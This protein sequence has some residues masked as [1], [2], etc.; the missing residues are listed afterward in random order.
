MATPQDEFT[1]HC[2]ELLAALGVPRA[3]RMFGGRGLY[4]DDLFVALIFQERLFLKTDEASRAQFQAAGSEPFSYATRDGERTLTSYWS[5][6][7]DAMDSPAQMLPWARLA[8]ASALRAQAAK[9][10]ARASKPRAAKP[11]APGAKR[12]RKPA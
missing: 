8:M 4:V 12:V 5:A 3:N 2:L 6:P 7:E 10:P 1:A 9:R 11:R